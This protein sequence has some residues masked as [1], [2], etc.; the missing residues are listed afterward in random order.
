MNSDERL[1][2]ITINPAPTPVSRVLWIVSRE[3][4]DCDETDEMERSLRRSITDGT[5][6]SFPK[7]SQ[8]QLVFICETAILGVT[9]L[10]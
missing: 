6:V 7:M 8:S 4:N 3:G 2:G 1:R 10:C 9:K 5:C